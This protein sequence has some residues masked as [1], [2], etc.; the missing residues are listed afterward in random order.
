MKEQEVHLCR[1]EI[2]KDAMLARS[3]FDFTYKH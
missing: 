3:V 2:V 1:G